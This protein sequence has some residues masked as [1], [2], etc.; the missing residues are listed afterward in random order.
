MN[1]KELTRSFMMIEMNP[2]VS[3]VC[4]KVYKRFNMFKGQYDFLSHLFSLIR[5]CSLFPTQSPPSFNGYLNY[6]L[7][8]RTLDNRLMTHPRLS[9]GS[10]N[11]PLSSS[12]LNM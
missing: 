1:Q 3:V 12:D 2:L 5:K 9:P 4:I 6:G 10:C 8:C 11:Y 7:A